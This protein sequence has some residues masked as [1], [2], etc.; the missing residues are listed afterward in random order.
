MALLDAGAPSLSD[1]AVAAGYADQAH[2]TREFRR[3]GG[4]TPA[5]LVP[6]P[7]VRLAPQP[8]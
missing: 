2:M 6:A 8:A 1:V 4:F 3:F 5:L 7:L